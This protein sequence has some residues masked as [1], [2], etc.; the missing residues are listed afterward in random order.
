MRGLMTYNLLLKSAKSPEKTAKFV[1]KLKENSLP[2]YLG[3][4]H[5]VVR[6]ERGIKEDLKI[7]TTSE[8]KTRLFSQQ[9]WID[10]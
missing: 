9:K 10:S 5:R 6:G 2:F 1:W 8:V 4:F 7:L 3:E